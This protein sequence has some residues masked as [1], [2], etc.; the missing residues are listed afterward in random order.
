MLELECRF[1]IFLGFNIT[2]YF[3]ILAEEKCKTENLSKYVT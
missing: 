2:N 1:S 3:S